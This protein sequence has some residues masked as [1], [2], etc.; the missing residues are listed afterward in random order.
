MTDMMGENLYSR[1]SMS[2]RAKASSVA[3][4]LFSMNGFWRSS[5]LGSTTYRWMALGMKVVRSMPWTDRKRTR[6]IPTHL[7]PRCQWMNQI[8]PMEV[9]AKKRIFKPIMGRWNHI[10][11][12]PGPKKTLVGSFM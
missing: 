10:S 4:T 12:N 8:N 11:T 1:V 7:I 5:S 9:R 3:W 6:K 2:R